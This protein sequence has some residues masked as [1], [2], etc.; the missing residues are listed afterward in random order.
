MSRIIENL[1]EKL[2]DEACHQIDTYG[3]NAMTIR[4]LSKACGV[5]VGTVYNYYA[6]KDEILE[7]Y[8]FRKWNKCVEAIYFI[9]RYSKTYDAVIHCIY[10]QIKQFEADHDFLF[11]D[12]AVS[13][14]IESAMFRFQH[15]MSRQLAQPLRKY[16]ASDTEAEIV[17][18]ALMI[19]IRT[20][21][22]YDDIYK[23]VVK[24]VDQS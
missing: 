5:A 4:S 9:S 1:K 6:S 10:D 17:A 11:Q 12:E 7:A 15:L 19:W 22:N 14:V 3:H 18:E 20:G 24:L 23:N 2:L 16:C 8:F 21:K 13:H